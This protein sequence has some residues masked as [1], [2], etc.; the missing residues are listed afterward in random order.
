[1]TE[2]VVP[3]SAA[4]SQELILHR[5]WRRDRRGFGCDTD[6]MCPNTASN[7]ITFHPYDTDGVVHTDITITHQVCP[8]HR[9]HYDGLN[10][11]TVIRLA[12]RCLGHRDCTAPA[13]LA[14][15]YRMVSGDD[16]RPKK[17]NTCPEHADKYLNRPKTFTPIATREMKVYIPEEWRDTV[18]EDRIP[19]PTGDTTAIQFIAPQ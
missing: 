18:S 2:N 12:P 11:Y 16:P 1:M 13:T 14:I 9:S 15:E 6:P 3:T 8:A 19:E 7:T 5:R 4:P 17:I 10:G